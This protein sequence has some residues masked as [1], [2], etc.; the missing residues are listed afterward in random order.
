MSRPT[1]AELFDLTGKTAIVTGA[2]QGIG[3]AAALRLAEAGAHVLLA[4]RNGAKL[5][6]TESLIAAAGG[7]STSIEADVCIAEDLDRIMAQASALGGVE[8]LVN[9]VGGM[10]PF[11]PAQDITDEMFDQTINANLKS[12]FR[13]SRAVARTMLAAGRGGRIINVASI[14][15]LK[16]DPMLAIYSASKAAVVSLTQSLS[17]EWA[18]HGILVNAIAPGP[19]T[20]PHIAPVL[21]APEIAEIITTRTPVGCPAEPDDIGNAALFLASGAAK[22]VTGTVLVVDG[23]M[24]KT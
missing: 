22:H 13:L 14:A 7:T 19:T 15:G 20:T 4:G 3:Q 17:N 24:T 10:H 6:G 21:A 8:I 1:I 11:T 5:A 9:A 16:P 2:A 18:R 12:A 23:G